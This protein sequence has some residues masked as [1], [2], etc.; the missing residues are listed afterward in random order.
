MAQSLFFLNFYVSSLGIDVCISK[1]KLSEKK[2][3][4]KIVKS[5]RG[6][7]ILSTS[8]L[9]TF[10]WYC[11][12]CHNMLSYFLCHSHLLQCGF[13]IFS[14]KKKKTNNND[15]DV[16]S[17]KAKKKKTTQ[18]HLHQEIIIFLFFWHRQLRLKVK[19]RVLIEFIYF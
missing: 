12:E 4:K 1:F 2:I 7:E 17:L 6:V 18:V 11:N 14:Q 13:C 10:D 9:K 19:I 16:S 3:T 8:I 5:R 15:N